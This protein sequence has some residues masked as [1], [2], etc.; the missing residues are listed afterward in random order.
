M[1]KKK[2]EEQS[3][4]E[5]KREEL[6]VMD[7][8]KNIK[9]IKRKFTNRLTKQINNEIKNITFSLDNISR[10]IEYLKEVETLYNKS[11]SEKLILL[12]NTIKMIDSDYLRDKEEEEI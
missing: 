3:F 7:E 6:V 8:M 11:I 9:N 2:S 5:I 12:S 4:E 10:K 1:D